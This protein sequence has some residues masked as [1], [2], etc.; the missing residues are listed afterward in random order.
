MKEI[1]RTVQGYAVST[2]GAAYVP[3]TAQ[4]IQGLAA[5]KRENADRPDCWLVEEV[6]KGFQQMLLLRLDGVPAAEL[7][8]MTAEMWVTVVG[9]GMEEAI[10]RPRVNKGFTLLLRELRKWPQPADLLKALPARIKPHDSKTTEAP[11]SDEE[12]A[13]QAE[14]LQKIMDK[15][16]KGEF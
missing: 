13:R 1:Q 5:W 4:G 3:K 9:E 16:D 2:T 6:C 15:L 7:V 12:H 8:A 14:E 11:I 10:D